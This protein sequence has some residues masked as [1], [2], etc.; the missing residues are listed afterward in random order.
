MAS[1]RRSLGNYTL[2]GSGLK[3]LMVNITPTLDIQ[4]FAEWAPVY[5]SAEGV[6]QIAA[7]ALDYETAFPDINITAYDGDDAHTLTLSIPVV[8]RNVLDPGCF[9]FVPDIRFPFQGLVQVDEGMKQGDMITGPAWYSVN[10]D[11]LPQE[12]YLVIPS[13]TM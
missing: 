3:P 9:S 7:G 4:T 1:R 2:P 6:L 13:K 8:L 11:K 10:Q 5:L 12:F